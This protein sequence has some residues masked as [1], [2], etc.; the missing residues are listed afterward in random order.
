[1]VKTKVQDLA[2]EFGISAD[3]LLTLL[4]DM[5]VTAR[6][7]ASALDDSQVSAVRVRWER[8]KRRQAEPAAAPKKTVR[9][10]TAKA[11]EPEP[12]PTEAA[13]PWSGSGE[14]DPTSLFPT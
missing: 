3:Q 6:S 7:A 14:I 8:E 10:K 2:T 11:A 9:R 13:R 4:R 1:M 5:G 12:E